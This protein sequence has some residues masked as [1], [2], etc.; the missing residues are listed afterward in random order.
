MP[1]TPFRLPQ[2]TRNTSPF[3][4]QDVYYSSMCLPNEYSQAPYIF[5]KILKFPFCYLGKHGHSSVVYIDDTYLQGDSPQL[6][7]KN[8]WDTEKLLRDLGFQIHPDKSVQIPSQRLEFLGFMLDS[9]ALTVTLTAKCKHKILSVS[10][11]LRWPLPKDQ[12][13]CL[14]VWLSYCGTTRS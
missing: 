10:G 13:Y 12:G 9:N 5:T 1:I 6:C 3:F 11:I 7:Q 4:W 2:I 8:I 14:S